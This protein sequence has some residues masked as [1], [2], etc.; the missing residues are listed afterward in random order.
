[1]PRIAHIA[2]SLGAALLACGHAEATTISAQS[3]YVA[4]KAGF[5]GKYVG[6][7]QDRLCELG[8][9]CKPDYDPLVLVNGGMQ[10]PLVAGTSPNQY[11]SKFTT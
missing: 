11:V 5:G 2:L 4:P 6:V 7:N 9:R 3:K 1:M 10:G 8:Y